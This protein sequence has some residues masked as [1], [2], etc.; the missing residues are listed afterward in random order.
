LLDPHHGPRYPSTSDSSVLP[1]SIGRSDNSRIDLPF[2]SPALLVYKPRL[3]SSLSTLSL[4]LPPDPSLSLDSPSSLVGTGC[5]AVVCQSFL[6]VRV[7]RI[8]RHPWW[9]IAFAPCI[10]AGFAGSIGMAIFLVSCPLS[11]VPIRAC[12]VDS[13]S[14]F[15][16][17][18]SQSTLLSMS[19]TRSRSWSLCGLSLRQLLIS[20]S[21]R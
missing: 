12:D 18:P 7:Y 20:S 5:S 3:I 15:L 13:I 16:F 4:S 9:L 14:P 21:L 10:A 17:F 2:F 1:Q 6:A 11:C 8:S 19:D